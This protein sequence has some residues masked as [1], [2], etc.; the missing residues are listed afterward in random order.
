M[1]I[2]AVE[3]LIFAGLVFLGDTPKTARAKP[4]AVMDAGIAVLY[5]MYFAGL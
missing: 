3:K 5:L 4:M 2:G 1:I